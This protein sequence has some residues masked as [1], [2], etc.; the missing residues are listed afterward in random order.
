MASSY[1]LSIE[2][3]FNRHQSPTAEAADAKCVE[4]S[5]KWKEA[6]ARGHQDGERE[7]TVSSRVA[8]HQVREE[9]Q[10]R[11]LSGES[12]PGERLAQQQLARELGVGQGIV[13]ESLIELKWIGLVESIERLGAFVSKIDASHLHE[14]CQ[15]REFLE[16]LAARLACDHASQA[17]LTVLRKIADHIEELSNQGNAEEM[18][19]AD[20]AFH[21][22]ITKLSHNSILLRLAEGYRVLSMA[23]RDSRDPADVHREHLEI[24]EAIGRYS[25]DEAE[26]LA[27]QHVKRA[28][29]IIEQALAENAFTPAPSPDPESRQ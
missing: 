27:R 7:M 29:R 8:R 12:R 6:P 9:L 10:R 3:R 22:H 18:E 24:I 17:D 5:W 16:G 14:A 19:I 28:M 2:F 26:Q 25:P 23:V 4:K 21:L 1:F 15:V 20:R 13:R 11:I